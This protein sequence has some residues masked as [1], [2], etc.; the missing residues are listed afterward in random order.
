VVPSSY[1]VRFDGPLRFNVYRVDNGHR[2]MDL[3]T[4]TVTGD[5]TRVVARKTTLWFPRVDTH[6]GVVATGSYRNAARL[7]DGPLADTPY[8]WVNLD[9]PRIRYTEVLP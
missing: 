3:K 4:I 2:I 1:R 5:H 6:G 9:N 8:Q 7:L